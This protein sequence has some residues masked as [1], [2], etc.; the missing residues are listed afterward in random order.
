VPQRGVERRQL[1]DR[2]EPIRIQKTLQDMIALLKNINSGVSSLYQP[3][4]P[5]RARMRAYF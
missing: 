3:R 1:A 4:L 5:G 2:D